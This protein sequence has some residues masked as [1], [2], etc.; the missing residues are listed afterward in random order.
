[1]LHKKNY[2]PIIK[3]HYIK[4]SSPLKYKLN[5][6]QNIFYTQLKAVHSHFRLPSIITHHIV[7]KH[8]AKMTYG[9]K[10]AIPK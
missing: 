2:F 6:Y 7:A 5:Q 9:N 3:L 10:K 1:M 8:R 4:K